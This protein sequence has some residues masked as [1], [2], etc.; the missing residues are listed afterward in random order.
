LKQ[1]FKA[2][3]SEAYINQEATTQLDLGNRAAN[4]QRNGQSDK[5]LTNMTD[6]AMEINSNV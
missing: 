3:V 5:S 6:N 4:H 2:C 1:G